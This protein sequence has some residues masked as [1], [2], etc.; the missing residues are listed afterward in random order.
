M[1]RIYDGREFFWQWDTNQR[2]IVGDQVCC[3]VHFCNKTGDCS[4]VCKVY[5]E[6]GLRLV[7]VPN[8]LLQTDRSITAF[9]Y[10]RGEN[11][12]YTRTA[13]IFIVRSRTKPSDYVYTETEVLSYKALD[14]RVTALEENNE[15]EQRFVKSVNGQTP[16]EAGNV[17]IEIPEGGGT[18]T[19]EQIAR[20][21]EE[22]LQNNP[23][24]GG[25]N[26]T[27]DGNGNVVIA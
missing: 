14:K 20:A 1:F 4:L 10:V 15:D 9:A 22:Y 17:E 5:V 7:N 27:D 19:D 16:D 6:D 13:K 26:I 18:V 21:V 25:L 23:V 2:L 24:Q 11:G 3:E 12:A 8:A